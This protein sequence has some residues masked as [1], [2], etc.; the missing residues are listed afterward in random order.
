MTTTCNLHDLADAACKIPKK[1]K[2]PRGSK[3]VIPKNTVLRCT[4]KILHII[5]P[6]CGTSIPC[7][8]GKKWE[9]VR[10]DHPKSFRCEGGA[11]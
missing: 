10:C 11:H 1:M 8:G 4:G 9:A 6:F 2:A 5:T 3:A 7:T